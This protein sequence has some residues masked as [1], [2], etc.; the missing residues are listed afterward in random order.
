MACQWFPFCNQP[1]CNCGLL[2]AS[3][4]FEGAPSIYRIRVPTLTNDACANC[5]VWSGDFELCYNPSK[6]LQWQSP[7]Y[8]G[9]QCG[10]T[11]GSPLWQLNRYGS[12]SF[13]F[14]QLLAV[15]LGYR[16]T[17]PLA[18]WSC[19]LNNTLA[20]AYP[21][22][23]P[24]PC[25][26]VPSEIF[27]RSCAVCNAFCVNGFEAPAHVQIEFSTIADG[28]CGCDPELMG[29]TFV[30]DPTASATG[31]V[32]C[33]WQLNDIGNLP[34]CA[35]Y[36]GQ[37]QTRLYATILDLGG[38]DGVSW[39]VTLQRICLFVDTPKFII[40]WKW[41]S[42]SSADID[43]A[44]PRTLTLYDVDDPDAVCDWTGSTVT[45]TPV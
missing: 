42:G 23:L 26:S 11:S 7:A 2:P 14:Y 43:C 29:S 37:C 15:G 30:L 24:G 9:T 6:Y 38:A 8:S 41:S 3:C 13:I 36:T 44:I 12:S 1:P 34:N 40:R 22:P 20:L 45:L 5:D 33:Q 39:I 10:H 28:V 25:G 35:G 21:L 4:G 27:L 31:A 18:D 32:V 17:L 19:T 16:W